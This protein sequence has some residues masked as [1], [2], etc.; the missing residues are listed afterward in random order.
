MAVKSDFIGKIT[1][2][3]IF[4]SLGSSK[5]TSL[6]QRKLINLLCFNCLLFVRDCWFNFPLWCASP[7]VWCHVWNFSFLKW[8]LNFNSP[9]SLVLNIC[10]PTIVVTWEA[11]TV[12]ELTC[13]QVTVLSTALLIF[14]HTFD[15]SWIWTWV[16][17]LAI[18]WTK[19][20]PLLTLRLI[21]F[22]PSSILINI[23]GGQHS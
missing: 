10:G 6:N 23:W 15:P 2:Q 18:D 7:I 4:S 1:E 5:L 21:L 16:L 9:V 14:E 17:A 13:V 19:K 8:L 3:S 12:F 22:F 20:Q 11:Y